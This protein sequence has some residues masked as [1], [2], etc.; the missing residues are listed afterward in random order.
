[1]RVGPYNELDNEMQAVG[2]AKVRGDLQ[3][4]LP[5]Q[6]GAHFR[7]RVFAVGNDGLLSHCLP[8]L[9]TFDP[10]RGRSWSTGYPAAHRMENCQ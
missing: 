8:S 9:P 4:R 2:S 1:M 10:I 3:T 7:V 6:G 5:V